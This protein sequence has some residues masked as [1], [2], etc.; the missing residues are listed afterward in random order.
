MSVSGQFSFIGAPLRNIRWSWGAPD[1]LGRII[2]RTWTNEIIEAGGKRYVRLVHNAAYA[3]KPKNLG[4]RERVA[5][6]DCVKSGTPGYA[7]MVTAKE[8]RTHPRK[9]ASYDKNGVYEI[10]SVR[11]FDGDEFGELGNYISLKD[12]M[13][14]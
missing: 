12:F 6:V 7:L 5:Q 14:R 11:M 2:L 13:A 1:S 8:P 3:D 9:I 4:F 10:L